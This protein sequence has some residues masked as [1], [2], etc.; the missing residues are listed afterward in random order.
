VVSTRPI[1]TTQRTA[2]TWAKRTLTLQRAQGP[3]VVDVWETAHPSSLPPVL[4]I[5]GWGGTGSYW[6]STAEFLAQ[7]VN[8]IVPDLPGTGRSQPVKSA[9]TMYDQI[10]ALV[11]V[12]DA[13]GLDCVQ[14][15]G[16]SMGGAMALLLADKQPQRVERLVLT[17]VSFFKTHAQEQIYS[18]IMQAFKASMLYRPRWLADMP[19]VTRMMATRYFHNI[20]DDPALLRQG[21]L[22]FLELDRATATAC[23]DNAAD[24]TIPKAGERVQV[25]VMI[26]ACP[27]DKVMPSENVDYTAKIIP[28]CQ[29]RWIDQCGHMP[30]IEKADEYRGILREFIRLN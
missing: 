12:L 26:I 19:S 29:V 13:L 7:Y 10:D 8:V 3:L 17:S 1:E 6:E 20:P 21:L 27:Q 22:D 9:Q 24:K 30:M 2:P 15:N 4:L 23:A 18:V 28:D 5:H 16:H 25:P 14:V 11:D